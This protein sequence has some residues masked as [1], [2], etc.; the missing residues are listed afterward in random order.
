[1]LDRADGVPFFLVAWAS[2][3]CAGTCSPDAALHAIPPSVRESIRQRVVVLP[4]VVRD[5]LAVAA[6]ARGSVSLPVLLTAAGRASARTTRQEAE[7]LSG[8]EAACTAGLLC[9]SAENGYRF[10]REIV[11]E[12]VLDDLGGARRAI[13]CREIDAALHAHANLAS[14]GRCA[15]GRGRPVRGCRQ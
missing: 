5:V 10:R 6:V 7:L 3:L 12:T 14:S 11:R 4:E 2:E 15:G 9:E 13:L 8:V 1:M